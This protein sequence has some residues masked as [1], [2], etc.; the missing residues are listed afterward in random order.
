MK[1]H[2]FSL[3]MLVVTTVTLGSLF[4]T[5]C[6]SENDEQ[7][8][9]EEKSNSMD[10]VTTFSKDE[11]NKSLNNVSQYINLKTRGSDYDE[12]EAEKVLVPFV[13]DGK[14]IQAQLLDDNTLTKEQRDSINQLTDNELAILSVVAYSLL[15]SNEQILTRSSNILQNKT[16][17]CIGQALMGGGSLTG[18]LTWQFIRRVGT[19][20]V[21]R[22]AL[23]SFGGMVGGAIT[24]AM[25]INDYNICMS[26]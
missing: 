7:T 4:F 16:L 10:L 23:S 5:S 3:A 8:I 12:A 18:G 26:H 1:K 6:S 15:E 20:T 22:L 25:Y 19:R 14:N 17:H 11:F 2:L 9:N 24:A 13:V 21:L